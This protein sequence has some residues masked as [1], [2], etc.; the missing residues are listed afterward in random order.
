[1][2]V[3]DPYPPFGF[4]NSRHLGRYSSRCDPSDRG[5]S[6]KVQRN[7][8]RFMSAYNN[9]SLGVATPAACARRRGS[10][11]MASTSTSRPARESTRLEGRYAPMPSVASIC[12][13]MNSSEIRWPR[14]RATAA[15][16]SIS[17]RACA[18]SAGSPRMRSVVMPPPAIASPLKGTFQISFCQRASARLSTAC[19]LTPI[20]PKRAAT[21]RT[22]SPAGRPNFPRSWHPVC[23]SR[24]FRPEPRVSR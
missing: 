9:A 17:R 13:W 12:D 8:L 6:E 7:V 22:R 14:C 20:P 2:S 5:V 15:I 11:Q 4:L 24:S 16:S 23:S 1:M 10:P 3:I 19:A 21:V 18:A